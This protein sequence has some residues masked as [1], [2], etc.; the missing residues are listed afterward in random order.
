M[1]N[2]RDKGQRG[3]R[4]V[5]QMLN[6]I[7]HDVCR[8][9]GMTD[10]QCNRALT[11]VQRNQNQSAVGGNDLTNCFGLSIEIKRQEQLAINTWWRQCVAAAARNGELPV[12][13]WKQ[14]RKPWRVQTYAVLPTP[15]RPTCPSPKW[16][17]CQFDID[18]FKEWF[19]DWVTEQ[20]K[21]GWEIRT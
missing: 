9:L 10:E 11:T 5:A 20:I 14:N 19:F 8:A 18:T 15:R 3:E 7:I 1:V 12:L 2:I 13:M 6:A 21:Q 17:V 16:V 4:E